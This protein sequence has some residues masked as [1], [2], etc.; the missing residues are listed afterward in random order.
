LISIG[1]LTLCAVV[2]MSAISNGMNK[3]YI[4]LFGAVLSALGAVFY[5][6]MQWE[7]AWR[8]S[9][10]DGWGGG[11]RHLD[12][13]VSIALALCIS[14]L[15]AMKSKKIMLSDYESIN[16]LYV[17]IIAVL[18]SVALF[19]TVGRAA[20]T[21]ILLG[22]LSVGL[23]FGIRALLAG[24]FPRR[25]GAITLGSALL[26]LVVPFLDF[27][28]TRGHIVNRMLLMLQKPGENVRWEIW[29]AALNNLAGW[30]W[31]VG[32]GLGKFRELA[33]NSPHS[34]YMS[35]LV[36]MGVLGVFV[37]ALAILFITIAGIR[38]GGIPFVM[39]LIVFIFSFLTKGSL[40][41][42]YFY[43]SF[44]I[45]WALASTIDIRGPNTDLFKNGADQAHLLKEKLKDN[46]EAS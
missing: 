23:L 41:N 27:F 36:E 28:L 44:V 3:S 32:A 34:A 2:G 15:L 16:R 6:V 1:L 7:G 30:D 33:G 14:M 26:L 4:L 20:I 18:L 13:S 21:A 42:K 40:Y 38:K 22:I 10:V 31:I 46:T 25:I 39:F 45:A 37:V 24:S 12:T 35:V 29:G 5:A 8:L 43:F 11:T 9:M 17:T 19:A